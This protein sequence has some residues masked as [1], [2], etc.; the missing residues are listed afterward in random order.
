[1]SPETRAA[2]DAGRALTKAQFREYIDDQARSAGIYGGADEAIK[3]ARE[4]VPAMSFAEER[5]RILITTAAL[6]DEHA[7]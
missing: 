6:D 1:M 7:A 5:I 4:H 3:R 2:L